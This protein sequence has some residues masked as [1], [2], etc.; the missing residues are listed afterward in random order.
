MRCVEVGVAD[1]YSFEAA[2]G[3]DEIDSVL[4]EEGD[5]V[6]EYVPTASLQED[7][8]LANAKLL[9]SGRGIRQPG[10]QFRG[11]QWRCGNVVNPWVLGVGF[12]SIL[13]GWSRI[14]KAGPRLSGCRDALSRVLQS[15]NLSVI[16]VVSS[17][18]HHRCD[19]SR[20]AWR[21][22]RRIAFRM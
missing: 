5:A 22:V 2:L 18:I 13:L 15:V 21:A 16:S 6:P 3:S 19:M 7:R 14:Q 1:Y 10:G 20:G 9:S 17:D 12:E 11:C 8:A 4:V